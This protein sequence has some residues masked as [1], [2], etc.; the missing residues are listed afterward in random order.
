MGSKVGER[1][2]GYS[3]ILQVWIPN[4]AE[5]TKLLYRSLGESGLLS[6]EN[7]EKEAF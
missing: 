4:F 5:I 7:K 1:N 6:W 2:L 3:W